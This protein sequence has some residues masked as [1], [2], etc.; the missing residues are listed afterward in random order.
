MGEVIF[1]PLTYGRKYFRSTIKIKKVVFYFVLSSLIRTSD[2]RSKVLSFEKTQ[3]FSWFFPHL[4]VPLQP[5]KALV[6]ELA[7][8][9][10]LGSGVLRRVGSSPIW[11]TF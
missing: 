6:A 5:Q 3:E 7:D 1:V 4:F 10:D 11:R 8:A 2:L 9:P